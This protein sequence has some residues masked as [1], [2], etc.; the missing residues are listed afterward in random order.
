MHGV[1]LLPITSKTTRV[2]VSVTICNKN[3][4][5]VGGVPYIHAPIQI[6]NFIAIEPEYNQESIIT[7]QPYPQILG[8]FLFKEGVVFLRLS[9][10]TIKPFY[11]KDYDKICQNDTQLKKIALQKGRRSTN[12]TTSRKTKKKTTI[13]KTCEIIF[14]ST[15][16]KRAV[17]RAL[18]EKEEDECDEQEDDD[19]IN[20]EN[21]EDHALHNLEEDN[22][23]YNSDGSADDDDDEDDSIGIITNCVDDLDD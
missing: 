6:Q 17:T 1:M 14:K 5:T 4:F 10:N 16:I 2:S 8:T 12:Q 15:V 18:K 22:E 21:V 3:T 7:T 9:D 23:S 19:T 20:D 11:V 13:G